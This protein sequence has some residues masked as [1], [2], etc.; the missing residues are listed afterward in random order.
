MLAQHRKASRARSSNQNLRKM[1]LLENVKLHIEPMEP[2]DRKARFRSAHA[3]PAQALALYKINSLHP[4]LEMSI[5]PKSRFPEE[6]LLPTDLVAMELMI[7]SEK[8]HN[9][10]A[11]SQ[12]SI[13][14]KKYRC[15]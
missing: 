13:Q 5:S 11:C 3:Y 8:L 15:H 1:A 14:T 4:E 10:A 12:G 9:H 7:H 2:F 6:A